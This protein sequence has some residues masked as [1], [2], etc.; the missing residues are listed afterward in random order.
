MNFKLS[1]KSFILLS[2]LTLGIGILQILTPILMRVFVDGILPGKDL[3]AIASVVIL[4]G[5]NELFLLLGSSALNR[6]L[7]DHENE[8]LVSIRRWMLDE[9]NRPGKVLKNPEVFFH[10]WSNEARRL[11]YKKI[12][13]QWFRTKDLVVLFL[14]TLICLNISYLAGIMV[15]IIA[16]A[17]FI[18]IKFHQE[19]QSADVA[20]LHQLEPQE[21]KLFFQ[22]IEARNEEK[23]RLTT[24]LIELSNELNQVQH[25]IAQ[26]RSRFQDIN[27]SIRF[28]LMFSILSVG[29]YLFSREQV[30]MGSIWALILTMY[31]I[32]PP[33]QSLARWTFQ[34][35]QDD[36]FEDS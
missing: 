1:K 6:T 26:E 16:A 14:L 17:S 24:E 28:I 9:V 3:V 11:T 36:N 30:S 18:L 13:N 31:R 5:A 25:Q 10:S 20:R 4:I 8:H 15:L 33:L 12:K 7:D 34:S 22:T 19:N 35:R 29:G 27:G 2:L 21:R 23:S 32:T